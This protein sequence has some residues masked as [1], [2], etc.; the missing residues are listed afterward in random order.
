MS[1]SILIRVDENKIRTL[2]GTEYVRW[3]GRPRRQ[4]VRM[5]TN[6]FELEEIIRFRVC[7]AKSKEL[8]TNCGWTE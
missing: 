8:L 4:A 6:F 5:V 3:Y 7:I 2:G 1:E